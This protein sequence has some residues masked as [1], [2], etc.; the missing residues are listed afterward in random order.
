MVDGTLIL[1]QPAFRNIPSEI[2][3]FVGVRDQVHAAWGEGIRYREER[4]ADAVAPA[5]LGLR[6]PQ[7]GALHAIASHW[8]VNDDPALVVMPTGTGKTEV[9]M[10]AA[11]A[12]RCRRLLV[13]VPTDALRTQTAEKFESYGLLEKIGVITG[14]PN[15]VV[16]VLESA[17]ADVHLDALRA[18]NVVLTTMSSIGQA[19]EAPQRIFAQLFSHAFFDEAHHVE[20]TT[21][22]KFR[23][24]C[25]A[26]KVVLFTATPYREDGKAVDGRIIY[27]FPLNVAQEQGYFKPIRFVEVFEPDDARADSAIAEAAVARLR[28]DLAAGHSHVLMARAATIADAERLF[29]TIYQPVAGD[30]NPILIHSRT[31]GKRALL[32]NVRNGQHRIVV[33]VNMFGEGFD[34]P[35]LKIAALHAVHKSL[36][37]TLQFIGRFARTAQN[38]GDA[39]FV[40]NTA[41][42]GVPEALE[43]LYREDADWNLLLSDLSYDAINPQARLSALVANLRPAPAGDHSLDISTLALR[44]KIS[45]QV[46]R[47][48]SFFPGRFAKAFRPAQKIHHPLISER[49]RFLVLVVNQRDTLDWT[50]SREI[51]TDGWDL[52]IAYFDPAREFLYVHCSRKGNATAGLAKAIANDPQLVNGEEVFKTFARLQRLILHSVGLTSRSRNVRYQMFAGLDVRNAIDPVLQQDKMKSNVTGVGYENGTRH[53]VGCSRKGKIWS[54]ATGSLAQ[55]KSWCDE[56]GAKLADPNAQPNDF[57]RF[58]LIPSLVV[59]LPDAEALLVDWP[60]QL[61]EA[62]NFRFQARSAADASHDFHDCQ[63]D[64]GAWTVGGTSFRFIFRAGLELESLLELT[65]TPGVGGNEGTYAVRLVAGEALRIVASGTEWDI[66][67]FFTENPPLVRLADGSQLSGNILLKPREA[68]ADTFDRT[69]VQTLDWIDV[70]F[71]KESRWKDGAVREDS[72]QHHF[73]THLEATLATFIVDDDDTGES[74]DIVSVEETADTITVFLWHCKY[75]HGAQP[76]ERASDLYELCGQAAKSVKWTWSLETL[77]KHLVQRDSRHGRGRPSRFI[78]G[79]PA[80]LVTLRKSARKKFVVF[81]VGIVQPGFSRQDAPADHLSIVGS[82]NSLIQ[83]ITGYPL[84]IYGSD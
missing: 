73:I 45:T 37:V 48:D 1:E 34:L 14:M 30:L 67:A 31:R 80:Q 10:A 53:T 75:S 59:A 58:T 18:C 3:P 6:L 25:K 61:F 16:G 5:R 43:S 19:T 39:T 36:G 20:A 56:I 77:V 13:V 62:W 41:A 8:T 40:A 35:S 72:I 47:T 52:Y 33:C 66:A 15:P 22:K 71:A 82:T 49:D 57:L 51:V 38:V 68:L 83:T 4:E 81:R 50:D 84:L 55:W 26:A 63:L 29:E 9:M 12:S 21:W 17:P 64:L 79:T 2:A 46:Y 74:A 28:E 42:D 70:D 76:G 32:A 69:Q 44:P 65:L 23:A 24:H 54:M 7:V 60:D 27:E 11:I 78:R